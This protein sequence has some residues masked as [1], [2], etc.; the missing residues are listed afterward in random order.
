MKVREGRKPKMNQVDG[1]WRALYA[2]RLWGEG[3]VVLRSGKLLGC[4]PQ[5]F[6]EGDYTV[7]DDGRLSARIH[8]RHYAGLRRSIFQRGAAVTL[9]EYSAELQGRIIGSEARLTGTVINA[10][11]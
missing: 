9:E 2:E 5:Y 7:S 8:V 6:Y 1:A 10:D 4:D 11:Y 3:L